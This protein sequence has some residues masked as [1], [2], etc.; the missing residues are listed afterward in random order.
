MVPPVI[1]ARK[2]AC[3]FGEE[4]S[5]SHDRQE[6][7]PSTRNRCSGSLGEPHRSRQRLLVTLAVSLALIV[8]V[9]AVAVSWPNGPQG[10]GTA[11]KL[12]CIDGWI[13]YRGMCYYLSQDEGSWESS[14]H[15]CS[16]LGASLAVIKREWE[17]DFLRQFK[18]SIDCWFGLRR[19]DGRLVW[20]DNTVYNETFPVDSQGECAYLS[21]ELPA[22]TGAQGIV[23]HPEVSLQV[24]LP[25]PYCALHHV[26]RGT[27]VTVLNY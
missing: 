21:Y 24:F 25:I 2:V 9:V 27:S 17:V 13:W 26:Q 14:Q 7:T 5:V 11:A 4:N 6:R 18:G 19:R 20:V 10:A 1:F 3:S 22:S 15:N 23:L 8:V 12:G 16:S